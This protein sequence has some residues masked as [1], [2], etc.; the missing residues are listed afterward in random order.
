MIVQRLVIGLLALNLIGCASNPPNN[1]NNACA[2]FKEK[3]SWYKATKNSYEK[4]GV[5]IHVQLAILYQESKFLY[6]AR[7]PRSRLLGFIPWVRTSSAYGY[8]QVQDGTWK[9]YMKDTG[10]WGAD[11]DD[12]D[13]AVDFIGWYGK[14]T[15]KMLKIP[16]TDAYRLYLVYHEGHGGY[17]RKSYNKKKWLLK[18]ASKVKK[19][20]VRYRSQLKKCQSSLDSTWSIWPF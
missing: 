12:F 3:S 10:N 6:N 14:I 5:P 20:G 15:K 8:A 1:I 11:R 9:W 2:I 13:D 19:N 17:K 16:K 18:V 7:P 4:W